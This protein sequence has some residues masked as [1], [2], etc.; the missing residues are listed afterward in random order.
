[1]RFDISRFHIPTTLSDQLPENRRRT[2]LR[3]VYV[4][5]CALLLVAVWVMSAPFSFTQNTLVTIAPGSTAAE[6]AHALKESNVIR[7]EYAFRAISRV[8][9]SDHR[10]DPGAYVFQ[11]PTPVFYVVW[12]IADAKHGVAEVKITFTEGMTRYDM[13]S[14]MSS[15][16]PGFST[17]EFLEAASTSEGYLFPETY[18]IMPGTPSVDIVTR[19][20][21]QFSQSIATITPQILASKHSFSDA[22][23]I[24]SILEREA[25]GEKDKKIV[26]GILWNR[27]AKDMP[28]QVDAVFGYIHKENG[29]TPTADDLSMDSPFN[30]YRNKGLPPTPISNPGLESLLAAVKPTSTPYFYYLTG[31]DGEMHYAKTFEGHKKNRALYLD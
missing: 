21:S 6:F 8:T 9:G 2:I 30:T 10:L 25:K 29:Y 18:L 17:S 14:V 13:A 16:L 22:V 5:V 28:L 15:E 11:K 7:S 26:A 31:K 19:L 12:R 3:I 4:G 1:M 24:A 23:I 20:R 27:I